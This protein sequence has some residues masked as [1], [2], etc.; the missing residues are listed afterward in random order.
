[1]HHDELRELAAS[2]ALD[3]L[4]DEERR[5]FE[6]H[7][8][9]CPECA[10]EVTSLRATVAELAYAAPPRQAPAHLRAR[11]LQ[12]IEGVPA[13]VHMRPERRRAIGC[14]REAIRGG[15]PPRPPW[16]QSWSAAMR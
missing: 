3:A 13:S 12:A 1:M 7:V 10:A 2:Y 6:R 8:D 9:V 5:T 14:G 16:R 11:V 15:W 4:S